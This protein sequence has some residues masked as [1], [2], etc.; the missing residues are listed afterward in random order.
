MTA[1]PITLEDWL[2]LACHPDQTGLYFLGACERRITFYSQQV[3][4][5]CLAHAFHTT[6][7]PT[8][9]RTAVVGAGAAGTTVAIALALLGHRVDLYDSGPNVMGLQSA[10]D[11][12][13]HPHIYEWP[14][15]GSLIDRAHLPFLDWTRAD[16]RA[17]VAELGKSFATFDERLD[18]LTFHHGR[19]LLRLEQDGARWS[20]VFPGKGIKAA[21]KAA[22]AAVPAEDVQKF[23]RVVLAMGF[24]AELPV[25]GVKPTDY[26]KPNAIGTSAYE[27]QVGTRYLVS[28]NGDGGLTELLRLTIEKFEHVAFTEEFLTY[29]PGDELR[30]TADKVFDGKAAFDDVIPALSCHF[31]PL[32]RQNGVL[33]I[34]GKKLRGDRVV[35]MN[36][37]GPLFSYRKAS[38]PNQLMVYAVIEA[39]KQADHPIIIA[40]GRLEKMSS[41][42]RP[43]GIT[44]DGKRIRAPLAHVIP[45]HGPD[46]DERYK[47][48]KGFYD[49][50]MAHSKAL[51]ELRPELDDPPLLPSTTFELFEAL[52]AAQL[53]GGAAAPDVAADRHARDARIVLSRDK[54]RHIVIEQGLVRLA[55]TADQC[56]RLTAPVEIHLALE[57]TDLDIAD[58]LVRLARAS[59]L[60]IRL[61]SS[62][63]CE[64]GWQAKQSGMP[65]GPASA[66]PRHPVVLVADSL[67][68]SIDACLLR[69]LH[70]ELTQVIETGHCAHIG[71]IDLSIRNAIDP[72][73]KVWHATLA[74]DPVLCGEFL[75]LLAHVDRPERHVWNGDHAALPL[76]TAALV[77]MLATHAGETLHPVYRHPGN[78]GFRTDGKG[79]GT[80]CRQVGH[81]QIEDWT[82]IDQ[83]GVEALILSATS[84]TKVYETRVEA[85]KVSLMDG[86]DPTQHI[87]TGRR[88]PPVVI[89]ANK[90]WR[91]LLSGPLAVWKAAVSREFDEWD[92]RN[93]QQF[94]G[95]DND[96]P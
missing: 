87:L 31:L 56:E 66:S 57:P 46:K 3:R 58:K 78:L 7:V 10:S 72:T 63:A 39:A 18:T 8:T 71:T 1:K 92:E 37:E 93:N 69:L 81:E 70:I 5:L 89:Q 36:S 67:A 34:L 16:G 52:A 79:L 68:E 94:P 74:A 48:A 30:D 90:R 20:L 12:L 15:L 49:A 13:L 80:G 65:A 50:Y 28:G 6:S 91:T 82:H 96:A 25:G 19:K 26:W 73:W 59:G 53:N 21:K 85:D 32:L 86:L 47:P 43:S 77:L 54:A 62:M 24:G 61:T 11:R 4:A 75:R 42:G 76:Y 44:V 22:A 64:A 14:E 2:A 29:F 88:A 95:A 17:V 23:D 33:D 60:R 51:R 84:E 45:R 9:G 83:W 27:D 41:A 55:E 35:T 38:R 40:R